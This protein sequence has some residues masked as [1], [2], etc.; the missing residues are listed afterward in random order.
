MKQSLAHYFILTIL[1]CILIPGFV[2]AAGCN[3]EAERVIIFLVQDDASQEVIQQ[4]VDAQTDICESAIASTYFGKIPAATATEEEMFVMAFLARYESETDY[5]AFDRKYRLIKGEVS[6]TSGKVSYAMIKLYDIPQTDPQ[7]SA[8]F[9]K[10]VQDIDEGE[11]ETAIEG[12]ELILTD[13]DYAEKMVYVQNMLGK[14]YFGLAIEDFP[15]AARASAVEYQT[16]PDG[17]EYIARLYKTKEHISSAIDLLETKAYVDELYFTF[18]EAM[19]VDNLLQRNRQLIERIDIRLDMADSTTTQKNA[20]LKLIETGYFN[21]GWRLVEKS[22]I[23][24]AKEVMAFHI[25]FMAKNQKKK[26]S[27]ISI[28]SLVIVLQ[29]YTNGGLISDPMIEIWEKQKQEVAKEG[30]VVIDETGERYVSTID[31]I[32]IKS[33]PSKD[34]PFYTE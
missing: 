15:N 3:G 18:N 21:T 24:F 12:L 10:S 13:Y 28:D 1:S 32:N 5:P 11:Y 30:V 8:L 16:T 19:D 34:D 14:A 23:Q 26:P 17:Q 27:D 20:G 25:L 2:Y 4:V 9:N 7:L 22:G 33:F 6:A 31:I 29:P